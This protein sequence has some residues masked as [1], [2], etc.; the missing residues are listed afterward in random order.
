MADSIT[1]NGTIA[2]DLRHVVTAEGLEIASF[3][4][5][6]SQRYWDRKRGTFVDGE[7]NWYTITTFRNLAAHANTSLHKGE[8]VLVRGRVRIR[9][10]V[11]GDKSGRAIE[12][13]ADSLGHDLAHG[14]T[15]YMR[16]ARQHIAGRPADDAGELARQG[17]EATGAADARAEFDGD[18]WGESVV[19]AS[20]TQSSLTTGTTGGSGEYGG[21]G[22]G[23]GTV[24]DGSEGGEADDVVGHA[25]AHENLSLAGV[26]DETGDLADDPNGL[27]LA[28]SR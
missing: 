6:S 8:R 12:I 22:E 4:L 10:W 2:S 13:E 5:A 3:R 15:H 19:T 16:G 25:D 20:I 27:S 9:E 28:G 21:S 23:G 18:E 1:V 11:D 14:W 7:T 17:Q 26:S 24:E